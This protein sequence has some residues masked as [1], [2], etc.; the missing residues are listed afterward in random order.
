MHLREVW[1]SRL[2]SLAIAR[3][4]CIVM[5]CWTDNIDQLVFIDG[6][7]QLLIEVEAVSLLYGLFGLFN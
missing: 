6:F 1:A 2:A 3:L 4:I 5:P 7:D